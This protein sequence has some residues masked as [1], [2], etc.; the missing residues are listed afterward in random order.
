MYGIFRVQYDIRYVFD[1]KTGSGVNVNEVIAQ[2][3]HK[4]VI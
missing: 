4:P 3:F 2:E 1:K